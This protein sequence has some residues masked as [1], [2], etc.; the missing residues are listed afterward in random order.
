MNARVFPF[1]T[2]AL[3][4]VSI[5]AAAPPAASAW[6]VPEEE[7]AE[8]AAVVPTASIA[9]T[10]ITKTVVD[11]PQLADHTI[12]VLGQSAPVAARVSVVDDPERTA[13]APVGRVEFFD[14]E[15]SLGS[16]A[17]T[18]EE[19][20]AVARIETDRWP[21]SGARAVTAVYTPEE[22]SGFAGSVSA[23]HT[24][25]VVD[26][27]RIVPDVELSGELVSDITD[28]SLDWTIANIW[29]SNFAVGFEREVRGGNVTL[30]PMEVGTTIAEKQAYYFRPFTFSDGTGQRDAAGNRVISFT[31]AARLTSGSGNQWNFTDPRVHLSPLGEGYITA[32]FSGFYDIGKLQTYGPVRV[33]VATFSDAGV[34]VDDSGR[35]E[36]EIELNWAGQAV[37][38]GTWAHEYRDSFPNEFV[39]LLSPAIN[40]FFARSSVATDD[41]KIPHPIRLGF[42]ETARPTSPPVTPPGPP[43]PPVTPPPPIDTPGPDGGHSADPQANRLSVLDTAGVRIESGHERTRPRSSGPGMLSSTGDTSVAADGGLAVAV[44]LLFSGGVAITWRAVRSRCGDETGRPARL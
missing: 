32:E 39:A 33:T 44:A 7:P 28:A 16:T 27:R 17:T 42:T 40:L 3:L 1:L 5:V 30:P 21:T 9:D 11:Y 23:P 34:A 15:V 14:G 24:Y 18:I 4:A 29:F 38:D 36:S 6:A 31:G 13:G 26:T 10:I 2:A 37:A 12:Y 43:H 35:S 25:R 22:G 19:G 20:T 8:E 41:S